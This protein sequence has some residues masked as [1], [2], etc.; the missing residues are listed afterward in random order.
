MWGNRAVLTGPAAELASIPELFAAQVGPGAGGGGDQRGGSAWT[1]RELDEASNRLAHV[2]AGRGAGPG[3]TVALLLPRS[4]EA[5]V[6]ILAVI[7]TGATYLP[8]D[9]AHPDARVSFVLSDAAP[10]VG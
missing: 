2:L 10:V 4:A 8:I 1:Y 3:R 9:P 5:I 7:K 6:A